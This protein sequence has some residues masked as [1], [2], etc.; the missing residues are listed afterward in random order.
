MANYSLKCLH[1]DC[2]KTYQTD[3]DFRVKCEEEIKS[4][5]GPA[6]LQPIYQKSQIDFRKGLP[7]VFGYSDWLPTGPYYL[8]IDDYELGKPFCYKSEGLAKRLGLKELFIAFSGFWP[9][10]GPKLPTIT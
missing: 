6:L 1:P 10:R 2:G 9:E 3:P 5:H 4:N 8:E 7:G